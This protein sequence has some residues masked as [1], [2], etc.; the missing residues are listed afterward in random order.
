VT[1]KLFKGL[2]KRTQNLEDYNP[3]SK[4]AMAFD[5]YSYQH[6]NDVILNPKT[7]KKIN[8]DEEISI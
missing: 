1:T 2:I 4:G 3:F 6:F 5:D 8:E 7:I